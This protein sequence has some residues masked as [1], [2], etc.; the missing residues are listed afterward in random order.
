LEELLVLKGFIRVA[1][2]AGLAAIFVLPAATASA[3][4]R[5]PATFQVLHNDR[6]G[7]MSLPAGA[8]Y[9]SVSNVSCA[10]ASQLFSDFLQDY[11]GDLPFPWRGN[12]SAKSF[13]NGS[14]S[15]SVKLAGKTPPNPPSGQTCP[16]TFSVLHNDR[17]GRVSF[18]QGQYA[19]KL[20]RGLTCSAAATQF[21]QFLD[22]PSGVQA[23]WSM[24]GSSSNATFQDNMGGFG[25]SVAKTSGGTSG[26][27][28]SAVTCG[29]FRV[30]HD[31]NVGSLYL[32]KGPYDIVLPAGSSMSCAQA[33]RQFTAFLN[34]GA[35]PRPWVLN[36]GAGTF[37]RGYGSAVTFGV[38]PIN[39]TIR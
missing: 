20:I 26:G 7:A 28:R 25:F 34:A 1:L 31:D 24:T 2:L 6:I 4:T 37:S 21:A 8:Y 39:G 32:P 29:T 13:T 16:G 35:L 5:C 30:M 19:M 14:S 3:A 18:P 12:A 17:I 22:A 27:G 23:P 9:V 11:D 36:A 15:F 33:S 38:D 10:T